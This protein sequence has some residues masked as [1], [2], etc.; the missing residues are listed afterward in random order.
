MPLHHLGKSF[1]FILDLL[2]LL[3]PFACVCSP[4]FFLRPFFGLSVATL[5]AGASMVGLPQLEG[6][7]KNCKLG[8]QCRQSPLHRVSWSRDF[9]CPS[10]GCKIVFSH[11][12]LSNQL[13][14]MAA[15]S[16]GL[17][18]L[19]VE[20]LSSLSMLLWAT[21]WTAIFSSFMSLACSNLT[22]KSSVACV[23]RASS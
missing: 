11:W 13:H 10:N 4:P 22:R 18:M 16:L 12:D 8:R 23:R 5:C 2:V 7:C 9:D 17:D 3:L 14:A 15:Y 21:P 19:A 20:R 1:N 6:G